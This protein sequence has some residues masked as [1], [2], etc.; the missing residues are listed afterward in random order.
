ME[1]KG[2]YLAPNSK[3]SAFASENDP[4]ILWEAGSYESTSV[5]TENNIEVHLN[6]KSLAILELQKAFVSLVNRRL[7]YLDDLSQLKPGWISGAGEVPST[8]VLATT[9]TLLHHIASQANTH[10]LNVIPHLVMGPLPQGGMEVELHGEKDIALYVTISNDG[11]IEI[12]TE[13][14]GYYTALDTQAIGIG[15]KVLAR[16]ESLSEQ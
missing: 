13:Y 14:H 11:G 7:S 10:I 16:Y 5:F 6:L 9:K 12:N 8:S 4:Q 2:S 3:L 1:M 15:D